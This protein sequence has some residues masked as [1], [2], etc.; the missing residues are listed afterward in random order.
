MSIPRIRMIAG[1]NGSGKTTLTR[2]LRANYT[3]DFGYYVNADE[4]QQSL[5]TTASLDLNQFELHP[6]E[7]DIK[8]FFTAHPLNAGYEQVFSLSGAVLNI[9]AVPDGYFAAVLADYIRKQLI[10][11]SQSFTFETVMSSSDKIALL[12]EARECG[13]KTYLYYICTQDVFINKERIAGRVQMGEHDVPSDKVEA[14]Y[15]KSL[16]L[17]S[18]AVKQ[19]DRAYLFDNTGRSHELIAEITEGK[20]ATIISDTLP[21]WV[22]SALFKDED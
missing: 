17:L 3:F 14:R 18:E 11:K 21:N 22:L 20:N 1:P 2:F 5:N 12:K 9:T 16:A 8:A 15:L 4:L 6:T 7:D 10:S 13:Y 19:A